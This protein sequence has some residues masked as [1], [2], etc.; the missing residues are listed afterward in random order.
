M[1]IYKSHSESKVALN[2]ANTPD[3]KTP[4]PGKGGKKEKGK[5]NKKNGK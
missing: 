3:G 1:K 5:K 2:D 4:S